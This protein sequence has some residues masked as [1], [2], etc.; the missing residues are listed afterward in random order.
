M[1]QS[2]PSPLR[3]LSS[4]SSKS[5]SLQPLP[6]PHGFSNGPR[7]KGSRRP[8]PLPAAL[9]WREAAS[10]RRRSDAPRDP[11]GRCCRPAFC[12]WG[13]GRHSSRTHLEGQRETREHS[14]W[15]RPRDLD[16]ARVAGKEPN[17]RWKR[18]GLSPR[19]QGLVLAGASPRLPRAICLSRSLP[20]LAQGPTPGDG[21]SPAPVHVPDPRGAFAGRGFGM[22]AYI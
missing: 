5:L 19:V 13:A 20:L 17:P 15:V 21:S 2:R 14:L 7:S 4:E 11:Q 16:Q 1:A 8:A 18:K 6:A 9:R 22:G 10:A 12:T 3:S